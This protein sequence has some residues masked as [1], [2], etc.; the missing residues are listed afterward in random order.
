MPTPA[1]T[2]LEEIVSTGREIV[3]SE[4][5][6]GLTMQKLA[7][8]VGVRAPS[9]YKHLDGRPELMKLIIESVVADLGQALE[10]A[11]GGEDPSR[12]LAELARAFREFAHSQPESYRLIF[13]P[14]P[15]DWRPS[16]QVM[17]EAVD[18]VLR[19]STA[20]VGPGRALQGAR[21]L[22]AWAHGF[23]TMEIA[24]AFRMEGD[25]DE[26][27]AFGVEQMRAA[28]TGAGKRAQAG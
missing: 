23:L 17:L 27:F 25:V 26:A 3:E 28:L 5:V 22:T 13:A 1:R 8:T 11:V 16:P 12:D 6:D 14:M 10:S 20:L 7:A 4:G 21:L 24:G 19:T 2:S 18:A 15:D 9:L